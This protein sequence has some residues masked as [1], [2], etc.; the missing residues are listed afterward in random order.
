MIDASTLIKIVEEATGSDSGS[1]NIDSTS[2][3]IEGWDSLGHLSIISAISDHLG[4]GAD[5][6]PRLATADSIQELLEIL[7]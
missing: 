7:K 6:D 5:E 4:E 1:V 2:A 3:D